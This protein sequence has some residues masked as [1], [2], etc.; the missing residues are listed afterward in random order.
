MP[1]KESD[2]EA[3]QIV[4]GK[5]QGITNFGA[6]IELQGG[7]VGLV[8]ISE[9]ADTYVK[10]VKDYIQEGDE[11]KVKVLNIAGRKIA[12]SIKQ[13]APPAPK[14]ERAMSPPP[15]TPSRPSGSPSTSSRPRRS[16]EDFGRSSNQESVTL[17]DKI[18]KFLKES[19]ERMQPLK[20]KVEPR[21]RN[22]H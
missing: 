19:D 21:K 13:A 16:N 14:V 6:F 9:I 5:V 4:E 12:L 18:A 20:S 2:I 11:V 15:R 7:L 3:G 1:I 10:D 8:H 17:D 22:K